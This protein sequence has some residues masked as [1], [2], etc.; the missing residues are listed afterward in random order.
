MFLCNLSPNVIMEIHI[1]T[2]FIF[3]IS[4]GFRNTSSVTVTFATAPTDVSCTTTKPCHYPGD[5]LMV[6]PET[7]TITPVATTVITTAATEAI[8]M[9][10]LATLILTI[11]KTG[12]RRQ[13]KL[14]MSTM[15][16]ILVMSPRVY[17]GNL[18]RM[19]VVIHPQIDMKDLDLRGNTRRTDNTKI[20]A[21]QDNTILDLTHQYISL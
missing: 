13:D 21:D 5:G 4:V 10:I 18:L 1:I 6:P 12:E 16:L 15:G 2:I 20:K 3:H 8:I 17:R 19:L 9:T 14:S 11:L 7:M